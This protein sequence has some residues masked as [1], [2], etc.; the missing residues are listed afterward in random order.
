MAEISSKSL[1]VGQGPKV[2]LL[3]S[4]YRSVAED[5]SCITS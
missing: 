4:H 3:Y 2:N 5:L 1:V